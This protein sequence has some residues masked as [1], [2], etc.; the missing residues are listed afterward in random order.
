MGF[1]S[2]TYSLSDEV[3][4]AIEAEKAAGVSPN[5]FLRR[6]LGIEK[7]EMPMK[8]GPLRSDKGHPAAIQPQPSVREPKPI[9]GRQKCLHCGDLD[10][11]P[12]G[13]PVWRTCIPCNRGGHKPWEAC[14][15]CA[16]KAHAAKVASESTVC[17][18][19]A[20]DFDPYQPA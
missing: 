11:L 8:Q 15:V 7:S 9:A 18:P 2:K 13:S 17:D 20:V 10:A 4:E 1:Q 14:P 12:E 16:R 5:Q 3:I 19:D 6:L